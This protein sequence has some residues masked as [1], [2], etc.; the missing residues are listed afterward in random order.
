[1]STPDSF[2]TLAVYN[3]ERARGIVHTLEWDA[4]MAALQV[5]FDERVRDTLPGYLQPDG[6]YILPG[7]MP[8][9]LWD[10]I[11]RILKPAHRKDTQ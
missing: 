8:E 11:H 1:V 4:R 10:S 7:W 3:A 5:K 2:E 9:A 6:T